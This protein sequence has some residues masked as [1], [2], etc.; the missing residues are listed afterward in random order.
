MARLR[1]DPRFR[2]VQPEAFDQDTTPLDPAAEDELD[3]NLEL[4]F[5]WAFV[6]FWKNHYY[7]IQRSIAIDPDAVRGSTSSADDGET[8]AIIMSLRQKLKAQTDEV[9][10]LQSKLAALANEHKQEVSEAASH[11]R[12]SSVSATPSSTPL[13]PCRL[14][15]RLTANQKETLIGEVQSLSEQVAGL[16]TSLQSADATK[17]DHTAQLDT[18]RTELEA[19]KEKLAASSSDPGSLSDV[20][21]ELGKA[22]TRIEELEKA[23]AGAGD[24]EKKQKEQDSEIT[25]LQKENEELK[26]ASGEGG[27]KKAGKKANELSKKLEDV[28]K[29][30]EEEKNKREEGEKEHEDLLVLLEELSQKRKRDKERMKE[31]GMDV[32]EGEEDDDVDE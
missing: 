1:E 6:D 15:L 31:G 5:D 27:G 24:F 13:T 26:K 28:E 23:Q 12:V 7:T 25:R 8:A 29:Q 20:R 2:A 16:T 32:S 19:E 9:M 14:F 22:H 4:W 18:L 11:H 3:D 10:Q 17:T 21:A 30:L